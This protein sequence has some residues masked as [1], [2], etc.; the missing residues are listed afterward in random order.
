MK[1]D[2]IKL[3]INYYKTFLMYKIKNPEVVRKVMELL[4]IYGIDIV[5]II[6]TR[7]M[8]RNEKKIMQM[9]SEEIK[10]LRY[11]AEALVDDYFANSETEDVIVKFKQLFVLDAIA[12][13]LSNISFYQKFYHQLVLNF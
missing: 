1:V 12:W 5:K 7:I 13:I 4:V 9:M 8:S 11:I 10:L 2:F 3:F 6:L